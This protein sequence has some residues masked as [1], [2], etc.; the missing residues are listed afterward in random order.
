MG[1]L[2]RNWRVR[3]AGGGF[4]LNLPKEERE[5]LRNL[6]PQLK[7]VVDQPDERTLRLFPPAYV[8]DPE[9]N[10]EYQ[11]YMHEELV[12]S[13]TAAIERFLETADAKH[14]DEPTLLGWMQT[15]NSLRLV[16]GT[17]LDVDEE[18]DLDD[19]G[20]QD[21]NYPEYALYGY[22]SGLLYEIVEALG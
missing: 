11:R 19:I 13:K 6:L 21:P 5:L 4:D 16:L 17:I 14:V 2:R 15:I 12:A 7:E 3:A 9:R 1:I 8:D 20:T 22:L 10:D 18:L